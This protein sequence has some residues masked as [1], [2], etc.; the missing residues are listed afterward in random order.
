MT[1]TQISAYISESTK[2]Q[3]EAYVN[4]RGIKKGFLIEEALLHH[5]QVLKDIPEDIVIPVRLTL[6]DNSMEQVAALLEINP[7]PTKALKDLLNA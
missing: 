6:T 3:V 5:L 1:T 7:E 2:Q 4:R